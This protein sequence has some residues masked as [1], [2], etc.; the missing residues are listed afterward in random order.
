MRPALSGRRDFGRRESSNLECGYTLIELLFALAIAGILLSASVPGYRQVMHRALRQDA[1]LG[2]AQLQ[3]G[4]QQY[5]AQE[6]RFTASFADAAAMGGVAIN[7]QSPE[8]HYRLRIE[9]SPDAQHYR[10]VAE[11]TETGRQARD[12]DCA[13]LAIDAVGRRQS[14]SANELWRSDDPYRCWG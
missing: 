14:R 7:A 1:R 3:L 9:L 8:G 2:L 4:Q 13:A 11:P 5:F 10:A 12:Q 6:H